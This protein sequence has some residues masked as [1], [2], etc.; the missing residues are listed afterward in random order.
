LRLCVRFF[1][2]GRLQIGED[3]MECTGMARQWTE[4]AEWTVRRAPSAGA[5]FEDDDDEDED[6]LRVA[7]FA[8]ASGAAVD[9]EHG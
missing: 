4:W 1:L 8:E 7:L 9:Q 5:L 3:E 6:D 2:S